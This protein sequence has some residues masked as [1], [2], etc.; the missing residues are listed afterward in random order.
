[1][2][3][4]LEIMHEKGMFFVDSRTTGRSVVKSVAGK[5]GVP[6]AVRDVFLDNVAEVEAIGLQIRKLVEL[7]KRRGQAIGI[8]HPYPET[9]EALRRARKMLRNGTVEVVFA[10]RLVAS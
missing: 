7:A 1:M 2:N 4:V 10:S 9:L 8:C 3:A 6:N 5:I